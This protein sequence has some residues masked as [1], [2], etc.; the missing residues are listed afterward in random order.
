MIVL[1]VNIKMLRFPCYPRKLV[2]NN[3]FNEKRY[4]IGVIF[5]G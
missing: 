2:K 5:R 4:E 3:K 1:D